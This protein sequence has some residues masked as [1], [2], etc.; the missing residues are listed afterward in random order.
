M[1]LTG[2]L[3]YV[4][5]SKDLIWWHKNK[6]NIDKNFSIKIINRKI[7]EIYVWWKINEIITGKKN[8]VITK[9]WYL[10]LSLHIKEVIKYFICQ[11]SVILNNTLPLSRIPKLGTVNKIVNLAGVI[12]KNSSYRLL[13]IL[14]SN[15]LNNI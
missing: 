7:D 1:Y 12:N 2:I 9:N 10:F 5:M 15:H 11:R 6:L 3:F 4:E 14:I 13:V 8:D